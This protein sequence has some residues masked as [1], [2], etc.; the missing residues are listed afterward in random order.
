MN[1]T[2]VQRN[3][4]LGQRIAEEDLGGSE[5]AVYGKQVIQSLSDE[6]T[7]IYGRGFDFSTLYKYVQFY[8]LFPQILDSVSP[9][10]E[11][12]EIHRKPDRME[13]IK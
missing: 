3:W 8:R 4:L 9:K 5:H 1:L 12:N 2:L 6:L 7:R 11:Q 10:S 13:I